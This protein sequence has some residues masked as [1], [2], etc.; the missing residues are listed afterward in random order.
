VARD[1]GCIA[2]SSLSIIGN[3]IG[4]ADEPEAV[5]DKKLSW[6]PSLSRTL[7]LASPVAGRPTGHPDR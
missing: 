1:A 3:N 7:R 6:R 5:M 4:K 2:P